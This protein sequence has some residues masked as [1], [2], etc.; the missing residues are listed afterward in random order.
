MTDETRRREV[1][2]AVTAGEKAL[3]SMRE[4]QK[5]L[6]SARGWGIFDMLGGG[7][8]SDM[9]KHSRL[10]DASSYLEAAKLDLQIFQRELK[11]VSRTMDLKIDISGF[12]LFADFFFDGLLA[13]GLVH[14]KI[15]RAR[16]D[17]NDAI[18]RVESLLTQLKSYNY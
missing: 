12:L 15:S 4:A 14:M 10:N 6:N 11:D 16:D 3:R 9:V 13:D 17:V 7:L 2:Q 1:Q 18:Q 5:K 8:I